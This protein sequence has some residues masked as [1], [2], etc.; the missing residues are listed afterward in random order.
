[1]LQRLLLRKARKDVVPACE[2]GINSYMSSS[3]LEEAEFAII[4]YVQKHHFTRELHA[5]QSA[6]ERG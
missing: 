2:T 4:R 3:Q 1:M 6:C 5:L